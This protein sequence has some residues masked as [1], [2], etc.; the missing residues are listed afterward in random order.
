MHL[1]VDANEE[2]ANEPNRRPS[3]KGT[4]SRSDRADGRR[5]SGLL[6]VPALLAAGVLSGAGWAVAGHWLPGVA[7]ALVAVTGLVWWW[8]TRQPTHN[9]GCADPEGCSTTAVR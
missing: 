6:P 4:S 5:M 1:F 7:I 8:A 3:P 9:T 2:T